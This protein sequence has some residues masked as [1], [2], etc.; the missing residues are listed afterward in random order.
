MADI[1][2]KALARVPERRFASVADFRRALEVIL[3]PEDAATPEASKGTLEF[4]LR[5]YVR[6]G[7]SQAFGA[8]TLTLDKMAAGG[9]YDHL[10]GGFHRYA[11][12]R[13]W[14][15][16]HFEKMLYDNAQLARVYL[17]AFLVTGSQRYREVVDETLTYVIREMTHSDGGF[18]S[19]QDADSEG[20]EGKFFVWTPQEIRDALGEEDAAIFAA[21]FKEAGADFERALALRPDH[22]YLLGSLIES[23]LNCC[24]WRMIAQ[25]TLCSVKASA[26]PLV[27]S[28]RES[29]PIVFT[30]RVALARGDAP[31]AGRDGFTT[32]LP[33]WV[34]WAS[35]STT[36]ASA[37]S[38]FSSTLI[39][40]WR[41]RSTA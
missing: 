7:S 32:S 31:R 3:H 19:T 4:L 6:T 5:Q 12:D 41:L 16:P 23:K 34:E 35:L 40:S 1:L 11:T 37:C 30:H 21:M 13:I 29:H 36:R 2:C 14:L 15:V 27:F 28:T 33:I 17:Q 26:K 24:D 20:E 38:R 10:G 22:P 39:C 9:I 18:Y 25:E 8:A